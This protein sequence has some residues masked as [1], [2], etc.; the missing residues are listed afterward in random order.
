MVRSTRFSR[1]VAIGLIALT[2]TL[3]GVLLQPAAAL[4]GFGSSPDSPGLA[5]R[6]SSGQHYSE[7]IVTTRKAGK[8]QQEYF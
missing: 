8:G 1:R 3:G 2:L 6:C 4:A 7:A 5:S